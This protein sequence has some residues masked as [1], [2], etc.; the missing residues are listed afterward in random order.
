MHSNL[1]WLM[2]VAWTLEDAAYAKLSHA[3]QVEWNA[4]YQRMKAL[5]GGAY[6]PVCQTCWY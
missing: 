3:E 2:T 4:F 5:P 1:I 6:H